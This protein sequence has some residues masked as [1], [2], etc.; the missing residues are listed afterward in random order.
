MR[1]RL[2]RRVREAARGNGL[3]ERPVPRPGPTL[4]LCALSRA[5]LADPDSVYDPTE[6][7]DRMLLGLK[8]TIS[9]ALCRRADYTDHGGEGAGRGPV[10][11]GVIGII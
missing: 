8:G 10:V 7:N 9:E 4:Q 5:L 1:G 6:H 3:V 11:V 2:A